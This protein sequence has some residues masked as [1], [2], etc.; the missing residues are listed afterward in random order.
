MMYFNKR[1][2]VRGG[3]IKTGS[4][5]QLEAC[6]IQ[7]YDIYQNY[8]DELDPSVRFDKYYFI[9][10]FLS[11]QIYKEQLVELG[12]AFNYED[13][14]TF[15][16]E[17]I[18][19]NDGII[20]DLER[21]DTCIIFDMGVELVGE[22]TY[23]LVD[24]YFSDKKYSNNV[25][26]WTMY[27][28]C[29]LRGNSL[30]VF[31]GNIEIISA[32]RTALRYGDWS[33][34]DGL[35]IP[36]T[37]DE[38]R[39]ILCLNR[40]L[41]S[42]RV[43]LVAELLKRKFHISDDFYLSFLGSANDDISSDVDRETIMGCHQYHADDYDKEL[44]ERIVEDIYDRRLPYNP[45]M[46]RDE[47]FGSSH[48][49]RVSEMFPIRQKVY[50]EVITEFTA[51][52]NGLISISEK[53]PQAL[54]SK[55]PFIVVG[56]RGYMGHLKK[57]GF[58]TFDKFWS[59]EY[60]NQKWLQDRVKLIGG[61]IEEI[62]TISLEVDDRG[63][64]VYDSDMQE[65][66][67]HNYRHYKD[68]F[69][70]EI[71]KRI[72]TS[73]SIDSKLKLKPGMTARQIKKID[74]FDWENK[75][76]YCEN[77]EVAIILSE[78]SIMLDEFSPKLGFKLLSINEIDFENTAVVGLTHDPRKRL[79]MGAVALAKELNKTPREI[80]DM[81]MSGDKEIIQDARISPQELP[82]DVIDYLVDLDNPYEE[83]HYLQIHG[84]GQQ[85]HRITKAINW[86]LDSKLRF[87]SN[88]SARMTWVTDND[89]KPYEKILNSEHVFN[90]YKKDFEIYYK[91]CSWRCRVPA[92]VPS[93]RSRFDEFLVEF[94][95]EHSSIIDFFKEKGHSE[96]FNASLAPEYWS[97]H[98]MIMKNIGLHYAPR[99]IKI[100]DMG[101]HF[102]ITPKFLESEG[103]TNVSSTNSYKEAGDML[104][105]LKYMWKTID[106]N[107]M[108]I[109]I[110][111]QE[112]FRL[113]KKY[114]VILV[115][116]SNIFWQADNMIEFMNGS[117][118]QN[119]E[120]IDATTGAHCT[121]FTPYALADIKFFV[122]NIKEW[123]E[124]GGI[125]VVQ[126]YPF[127]YSQFASFI[128]EEEFL[129][130]YQNRA[131][132]YETALANAHSPR[133]ELNDYFVVQNI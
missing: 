71:D 110:R 80:L 37:E 68:N 42:N 98:N 33:W 106:L 34:E 38:P 116:M 100:L 121:F 62:L 55:K 89:I 24:K 132:G 104:P 45:D 49:D 128:A 126:P 25:K 73:L 91:R 130:Q 83:G 112:T 66:L 26:Y 23:K 115:T 84:K 52:D 127:V 78:S 47:W 102:G 96:Y 109:H 81:V 46:D 70:N 14:I 53:L 119:S 29:D 103:F 72:L 21:G 86:I 7:N 107:P 56:D 44:F 92:D 93:M 40:R 16:I 114:D 43:L 9:S 69:V 54:L 13:S 60:D 76:W 51:T 30:K 32:S 41:R 57:L 131:T 58:R 27:E 48:L 75:I 77:L 11:I 74:N 39:H 87:Q 5:E 1:L 18:Y 111:P 17:D 64:V 113:D 19:A 123:L 99:D 124:P 65:I 22:E 36:L 4:E 129:R 85:I 108:D 82:Y 95:E 63:V 90:M 2:A 15:M 97:N 10:P 122:D 117:V 94:F 118:S 101:T 3:R 59:E 67:E 20:A 125:A 6:P 105:D 79:Y 120:N 50:A 31:Q 12:D 8:I 88:L 133:G 28:N 35:S 61:S